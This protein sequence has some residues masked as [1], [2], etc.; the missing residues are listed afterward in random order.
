ME[1]LRLNTKRVEIMID[2][3]PKRVVRFNPDDVHLRARI[4]TLAKEA[5]RKQDA[6]QAQLTELETMEGEDELGLPLK[7]ESAMKLTVDIADFFMSEID[8]VFGEGTSLIVFTDG[9]DFESMVVFLEY[10]LNKFESVSTEKI[11]QRLSKGTAKKKA[12]K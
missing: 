9:F 6:M 11:E 10:V 1:S 7:I 2:D 3:D 5:K 12:M 4:Y 8:N